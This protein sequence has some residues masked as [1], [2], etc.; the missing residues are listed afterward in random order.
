MVRI[1]EGEHPGEIREAD[2]FSSDGHFRVDSGG[3]KTLMNCLM[4]KLSY[5]RFG[6]IQMGHRQPFGYDRARGV[7]IGFKDIKLEHMEEAFTSEHWLVRIYRVKKPKNHV[8]VAT[9]KRQA[10][11]KRTISQKSAR[12]MEGLLKKATKL[13]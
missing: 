11:F 7:E 10:K 1:A 12:K 9:T 8:Q 5:Y 13:I 4:Y 3:S 2:Y 6:E